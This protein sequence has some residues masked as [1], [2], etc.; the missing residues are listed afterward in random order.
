[1]GE[2][3][4]SLKVGKVILFERTF[5]KEDVKRFTKLSKDE[6]RH[7]TT[8]DEVDRLVVQGLLTATLPTKIGGDYN[9]YARTMNFEFLRPVF[10]EDTIVCEVKVQRYEKRK[11]NQMAITT[12]F[13]CRNQH[14]KEVLKGDFTGVIF[15]P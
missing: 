4:V 13:T 12:I 1:M 7:H 2:A 8:P 14:G 3:S 11:V 15:I 9:I 10:T 5:T 6:G